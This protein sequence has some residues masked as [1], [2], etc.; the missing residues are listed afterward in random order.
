MDDHPYEKLNHERPFVRELDTKLH[1]VNS[2]VRMGN[3]I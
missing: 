3:N 1:D 2:S